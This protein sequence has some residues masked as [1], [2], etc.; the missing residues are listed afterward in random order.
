MMGDDRA[1]LQYRRMLRLRLSE[2]EREMMTGYRLAREIADCGLAQAGVRLE[3]ALAALQREIGQ[4]RSQMLVL[5]GHCGETCQARRRREPL[6][7]GP[8][9]SSPAATSSSTSIPAPTHHKRPSTV[10]TYRCGCAQRI[11]P[12]SVLAIS[13]GFATLLCL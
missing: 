3:S 9:S 10:H 13:A 12:R 5:E 1:I 11:L 8:L 7:D 6:T 4:V 2:Y